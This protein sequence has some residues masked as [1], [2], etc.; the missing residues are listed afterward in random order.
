MNYVAEEEF[1][2]AR[3]YSLLSRIVTVV[4]MHWWNLLG[5]E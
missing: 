1:H 2:W 3:V 4:L 5:W